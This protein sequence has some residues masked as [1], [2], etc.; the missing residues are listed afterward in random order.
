MNHEGQDLEVEEALV[1]VTASPSREEEIKNPSKGL[2]E[3]R[4]SVLT[5]FAL[6]PKTLGKD[7]QTEPEGPFKLQMLPLSVD[8]NLTSACEETPCGKSDLG[9]D[10]PGVYSPFREKDDLPCSPDIALRKDSIAS[11]VT[12]PYSEYI[13]Y[14]MLYHRFRLTTA[15]RA[16]EAF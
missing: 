5:T 6:S 7:R 15:G 16:R 2:K 10:S 1:S 3:S 4:E 11:F 8:N 9:L 13:T 14:I 12:D